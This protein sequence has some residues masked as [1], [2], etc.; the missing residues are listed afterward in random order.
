MKVLLFT[1]ILLVSSVT[2]AQTVKPDEFS[3]NQQDALDLLKTLA[4]SLKSEQDKIGAGTVQA[5]IAS[6]LWSFDEPFARE[7]FRWAFDG[8]S[9]TT[10][11]DLPKEKQA[12]FIKR[13]ATAVK[14]VLQAFGVHDS[15]QA[16]AWLKAFETARVSNTSAKPDSS[17]PD[18]FMQIAAQLAQTDP[19]QAARLGLAALS[20]DHIPEGF[21]TLLF[22]LG[23]SRRELSDELFRAAI[24]TMRRNNYAYDPAILIVANYLFTSGGELQPIRSVTDAELL[25]NY[26]VDGAWKQSG[27]DGNPVSA[28]SASFYST[29]EL[30]AVPIVSRYAPARLP[31]LRGQMTR[32]ASGLNSEQAQRTELLRASQQ[33]QAAASRTGQSLD[34]RIQRA[35]KEKDPQVR[36]ALFAGIAYALMRQ[37]LD[38]A[39]TIAKKIEDE[40]MRASTEDDAYLIKMQQ[41]LWSAD[42][43]AEAHKLSAK[44]SSPVFRAKILVQLASRVWSKNK[45]QAQAMELLSEALNATLKAEDIPDKLLA[46][47]QIVEQFA[48]FES[49][50]AFEVLGTA[51]ATMNRLKIEPESVTTATAK[52]PLLRMK[53]FT[54]VNGVEMTTANEAT[55]AS[56]DFREVRSLV[57]ND[58]IQAKLL[59]SKLEQQVQR[60]NYL[61]AVAASVLKPTSSGTP[62]GK[63]EN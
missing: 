3:V 56:I 9:Q 63:K 41:L 17:R 43:L 38:H 28:S 30:R 2:M 62:I 13:Q 18:L 46:Q 48:K 25:A 49:V 5:R 21:G 8:I 44:F 33:Q 45:D 40:K 14:D 32:I 20:G 58:Y 52:P 12:N 34:E 51:I 61:T 36:D 26:Y 55:L 7:T 50:R 39:L 54:V 42:A 31:E 1:T 57:P 29:L 60:A 47:L 53:T 6:E 10:A 24:A 23:R 11:N 27:G 37:D 16:A 35:E 22:T 59:A 4:L 15:K 19:E